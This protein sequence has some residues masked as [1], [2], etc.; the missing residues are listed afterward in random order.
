MVY[1]PVIF[2]EGIMEV[3]KYTKENGI[4]KGRRGIDLPNIGQ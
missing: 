4:E 1:L 3:T 2:W